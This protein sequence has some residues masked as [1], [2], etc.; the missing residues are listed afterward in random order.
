MW[1]PGAN[2]YYDGARWRRDD[3]LQVLDLVRETCRE[4]A[5]PVGKPSLAATIRSAK[6]VSAVERLARADR[7]IAATAEQWDADPIC[8][9]GRSA[10]TRQTTT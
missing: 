6:T 9:P 2:G 8:K 4:Q 3:T 7:R 1:L 10:L 5:V